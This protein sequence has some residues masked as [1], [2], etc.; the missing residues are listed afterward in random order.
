[1]LFYV[2]KAFNQSHIADQDTFMPF[3]K[4]FMVLV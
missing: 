2:W 1:M 4:E 3:R